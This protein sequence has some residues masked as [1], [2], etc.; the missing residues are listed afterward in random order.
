MASLKKKPS[1]VWTYFHV[2]ESDDSIAVCDI[3][4]CSGKSR[5]VRRAPF[6][7]DKKEYSTKGLWSHLKSH[8][9]NEFKDATEV[10]MNAEEDKKQNLA[11]EEEHKAIYELSTN[12]KINMSKQL[13]VQETFDRLKK[14]PQHHP[15]QQS[16]TFRLGEW[17]CNA[18]LPYTVVEDDRFKVMINQ[19][20]PKFDIPS[21]KQLRQSIIPDMYKRV[22]QHMQALLVGRFKFCSITTDIWS[23]QSLHSFISATV[24]FIDDNW[25]PKMVV[26]ACFPFDESHTAQHI[27]DV[28]DGI[29]T[30]WKLKQKLHAVMRDNAPNMVNAMQLIRLKSAGCFLHTLQLVV[31]HSIF[32]QSGV[33]LMMARTSKLVSYFK[34]SPKAMN[35]LHKHQTALEGEDDVV[36]PHNNLIM[37]E[38]TRW[39]SYYHMLL[40]LQQQKRA[41]RRCEDDPD[42]DL[43]SGQILTSFDWELI[44]KVISLLKSFAEVTSDGERERACISE[45]IPSVK[46]IIHE[47]NSLNFS[48]IGT[49]RA[50]LL[51]QM[52]KYF[53]GGDSREHFCD[54][55]KNELFAVATLLD[56]RY[57]SRGF[58]QQEN[59]TNGKKYS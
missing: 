46:Y 31:T 16:L 47:I 22:Y 57:K 42:I 10:K 36:V 4:I 5:N 18:V 13:T 24:H 50:E 2:G 30:E 41:I 14:W 8:H 27:A 15:E 32:E 44:A 58:I 53:Q 51:Y 9:P 43:N 1:S 19:L 48:G 34:H 21:E 33:K 35:I 56:P 7:A 12:R 25:Q 3:V 40:R 20:N 59:V 6:A 28:L 52:Q 26:L 17:I 38:K 45:I 39:S 37:G 49:M 55:E 23:S 11:K 54:I 29:L